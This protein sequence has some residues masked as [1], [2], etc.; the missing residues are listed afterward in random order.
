MTNSYC[1]NSYII[2]SCGYPSLAWG[3]LYDLEDAFILFF[4]PILMTLCGWW[5]LGIR[6]GKCGG[7]IFLNFPKFTTFFFCLMRDND[8]KLGALIGRGLIFRK[9]AGTSFN[10]LSN[11]C[12]MKLNTS[13]SYLRMSRNTDVALA[14]GFVIHLVTLLRDFLRDPE[15]KKG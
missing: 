6:L 11:R 9:W 1:Y 12:F 8:I 10:C 13:Y 4:V 7:R 2:L 3:V 14:L 15:N 5:R